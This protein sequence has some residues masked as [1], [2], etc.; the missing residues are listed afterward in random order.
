MA[1]FQSSKLITND[2]F[3]FDADLYV[4]KGVSKKEEKLREREKQK[5]EEELKYSKVKAAELTTKNIPGLDVRS[6]DSYLALLENTFR[7][8]YD[9]YMEFGRPADSAEVPVETADGSTAMCKEAPKTLHMLDIRECA[10]EQEYQVF[11]SN[12]VVTT[13]RRAMA[14]LMSKVKKETD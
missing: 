6:R 14:F 13:Y 9:T 11:T 8:N 7:I 5:E 3:G 2:G 12:K 10:I 1:A 4:G